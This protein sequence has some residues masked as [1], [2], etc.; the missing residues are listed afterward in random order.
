MFEETEQASEPKSIMAGM[1][2]LSDQ[3][4]K[5]ILINMLEGFLEKI[6]NTQVRWIIYV[7]RWKFSEI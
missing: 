7:E 3:E 4:F 1:L 5:N 6:A 2:K